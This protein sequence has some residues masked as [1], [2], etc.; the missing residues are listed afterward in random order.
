MNA[1]VIA[2]IV[3]AG[4]LLVGALIAVIFSWFGN[5][6]LREQEQF[7]ERQSK[8]QPSIT[9]GHEIPVDED[10]NVQLLEARK[11]AARQAARMP[12]GAN[13]RIGGSGSKEQKTS[14]DGIDRDPM[15][16]VKMAYFHGWDGLKTGAKVE[17]GAKKDNG[18]G[19]AEAVAPVKSSEELIP[20]EDYPFIEITDDMSPAEKRKARIAN[21][22]A[23][24]AA[25]K[26]AKEAASRVQT[27]AS[28]EK[29]SE[30]SDVKS[31]T[32]ESTPVEGKPE[33]GV[34]YEVIEITDDMSPDEVRKARI[35]NAKAKSA[36]TKR[37]KE[38]GVS[39]VAATTPESKSSTEPA[40]AQSQPDETKT[41][42][43]V[44]ADIPEPNFIEITDDM[45]KD[46]LRKA[47]IHNAKEKSA[48]NKAL[49][50]AGIDPKAVK[51]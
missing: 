47:R 4:S 34:D 40:S 32:A 10:L 15:S 14:H 39:T 38:S 50:A 22:K 9:F 43:S 13:L 12:R 46:E 37:F 6:V 26:K 16:A 24:S 21:A 30:S 27:T 48:Y 35:Q 20:G 49:R 51:A 1:I 23:K 44:P 29:A 7:N 25:V 17:S 33:P 3:V 2:S 45:D 19:V 42:V 41:S 8:I 28:E 5:T 36:A 18:K 31:K 11:L